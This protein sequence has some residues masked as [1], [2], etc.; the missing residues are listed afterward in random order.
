M[1]WIFVP[2]SVKSLGSFSETP[3]GT[4][5]LAA[6]S[7][8]SPK[9]ARLPDLWVSTPLETT[10]SSAGTFQAS[11]AACTSMARAAAPAL[12]SWSQLLLTA[13]DPPVPWMPNARLA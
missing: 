8:R 2:I 11:T 13:V 7:A 3:S 6:A 12:R 4:G 9:V 5:S 1:R 10:I